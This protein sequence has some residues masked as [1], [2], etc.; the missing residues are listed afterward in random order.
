MAMHLCAGAKCT[1]GRLHFCKARR[2]KIRLEVKN[3][4]VYGFK[5]A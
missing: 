3:A 1:A 4:A 2:K 5:R